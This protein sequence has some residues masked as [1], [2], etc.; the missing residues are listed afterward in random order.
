MD[1]QVIIHGLG[2]SGTSW[3]MKI[4]DHHPRTMCSHEPEHFIDIEALR[5]Q[6]IDKATLDSYVAELFASRA[7]RSMRVRPIVEKSNRFKLA[8]WVR[9]G[10]MFGLLAC[11]KLLKTKNE[12]FERINVPDLCHAGFDFFVAKTVAHYFIMKQIVAKCPEMKMIYIIRH[13][14]G[15]AG[16]HKRGIAI[17]KM[18]PEIMPDQ[19]DLDQV[20][21]DGAVTRGDQDQLEILTY[22]WAVWTDMFCQLAKEYPNLRILKYEDL[23]DDPVGV[24]RQ[25]F[26]WAGLGWDARVEEFLQASLAASGD[27]SGYHELTRNPK[28]AAEKWRTQMDAADIDKVLEIARH[29]SAYD[30]FEADDR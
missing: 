3:L 16:S 15:Y 6:E 20:F 7:L 14:C 19:G 27:A 11:E 12:R 8:H 29:S 2:R 21:G 4:F 13:P 30:L 25:L 9:L 18:K 28:V 23:C 17:G 10:M 1:N 24:S 26:D 5:G 22:K